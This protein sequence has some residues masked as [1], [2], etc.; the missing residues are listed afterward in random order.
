[1]MEAGFA[2]EDQ[3]LK[4]G[5]L[6]EAL[7]RL[8]RFI[9]GIR[10]HAE[11]LSVEQGVRLF[12]EDAFLEETAARREA[13]RGTFDPRYVVYSAGKLMLL[14]LRKDVKAKQ[15]AK[16]TLKAFH[17]ALLAQGAAPFG[18][19]RQMMLEGDAGGDLLE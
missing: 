3:T 2:R 9:V 5:Q 13:E 6:Q 18:A 11:D 10:L 12:R 14:K 1:M 19:H 4:L 8:V 15:G 17:D 7:I 16:F